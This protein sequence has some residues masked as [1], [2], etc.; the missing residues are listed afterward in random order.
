M[1]RDLRFLLVFVAATVV[2]ICVLPSIAL[3]P[4]VWF[5]FEKTVGS[6]IA[7]LRTW[8]MSGP[9]SQY[10]AYVILRLAESEGAAA[11]SR[12]TLTLLEWL[13][14]LW[15]AVNVFLVWQIHRRR[16]PD[17]LLI[18]TVTLFLSLP[19]IVKTS[20]PHYFVY[21]PFCQAAVLAQVGRLGWTRRDLWPS[22]L[23]ASASV[24]LASVPVFNAFRDWSHY[25]GAGMLLWSNLALLVALYGILAR[26]GRGR[27]PRGPARAEARERYAKRGP[28]HEG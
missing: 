4:A 14:Y 20:W 28:A 17:A 27:R 22:L 23:L 5:E 16:S 19:L 7:D 3:G 26:D 6:A 21:L 13:G 9:D 11:V 15:F 24:V 8:V 25:N 18:S 10:C 12:T 2:F 1:K